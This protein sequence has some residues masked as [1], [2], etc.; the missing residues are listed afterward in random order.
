[1]NPLSKVPK[2]KKAP[3]IKKQK[4]QIK[5]QTKAALKQLKKEFMTLPSREARV[6]YHMLA[7]HLA[8]MNLNKAFLNKS[9][10]QMASLWMLD[11]TPKKKP[12]P[13]KKMKIDKLTKEIE[14]LSRD[15]D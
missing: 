8:L 4:E 2:S 14:K 10:M 1:M 6:T 7:L 13:A 9:L 5:L 12:T 15:F 3:D 11:S